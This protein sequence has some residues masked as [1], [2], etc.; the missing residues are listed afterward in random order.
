[1]KAI[2]YYIAMPF[3]Y[4][5]SLLPFRA[6]YLV[7]DVFY[8]LI[9]RLLGYRK[10]VVVSNLRNSFPDKTEVE[11][12]VITRRFYRYLCDLMLETFKTLTISKEAMLR[13]CTITP[14][15][16]ALFDK[17]AIEYKGIALVLGHHGNWEWA[18]NT[19]SLV[20]PQQLYVIYHPLSNTY[21]DNLMYRM[22][23][24][25]GTRLIPMKETTKQM[26]LH[27]DEVSA[28]AFIADQA[29]SPDNAFWTTFLNQ[30]TPVFYGPE[31]ISAKLN[32]P[33]VYMHINRLSRGYYEMDAELLTDNPAALSEGELTALHTRTLEADI[34]AQPYT[35]LWSHRRWKHKRPAHLADKQTQPGN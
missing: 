21:F 11:I 7:S 4:V 5:L 1:M 13:H 24:R 35:W 17:L 2:A 30:D 31:R 14:V 32:Y 6:L 34:I 23:S 9:Y 16:K 22:R 28:T 29:P 15:A 18:G 10:Q 25:F 8:A 19:F 3:I 26:V 12:E 33:V 20:C 27:R